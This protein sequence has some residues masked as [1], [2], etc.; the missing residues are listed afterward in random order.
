MKTVTVAASGFPDGLN[1]VLVAVV[2]DEW[3]TV[4]M[5]ADRI[6]EFGC[7]TL[8]PPLMRGYLVRLSDC[9]PVNEADWELQSAYDF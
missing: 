6:R 2:V 5:H 4:E 3:Q 9:S 8:A 1:V 7:S